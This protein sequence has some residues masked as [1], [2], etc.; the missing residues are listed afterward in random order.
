MSILSKPNHSLVLSYL[1]LRRAIGIIGMSLPFVL[2]FGK[3]LFDG[4]GIE[5]SIS[6]YYHTAMRDV[7]VGSLCAIAV[8]LL[9]Y[10][11]YDRIDSITGKLAALWAVG[12]AFFPASPLNPS[13]EQILIGKFHS[14]FA[15]SFFLTLAFFA[16]VLFR[17]TNPE[18]TPTS[19]KLTRNSIYVVCG[20]GILVCIVLIMMVELLP[21]SSSISRLSP[22]FWLEALAIILFG[23][24][25]FVKGKAIVKDEVKV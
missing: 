20:I 6:S 17:K 10:W 1:G 19:R 13:P 24:S 3:M 14:I 22:V 9:S 25:W 4:P 11:G 15:L 12:T 18:Q 21:V 7:F 16:L 23:I 8:F 5:S 2:V